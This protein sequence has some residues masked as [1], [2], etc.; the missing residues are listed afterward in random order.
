[1]DFIFL[2]KNHT[3]LEVF[4]CSALSLRGWLLEHLLSQRKTKTVHHEDIEG[5]E[6]LIQAACFTAECTEGHRENRLPIAVRSAIIC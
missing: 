2:R 5:H 3:P 6:G 1:V 4:Y